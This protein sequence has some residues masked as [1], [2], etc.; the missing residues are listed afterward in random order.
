VVIITLTCYVLFSPLSVEASHKDGHDSNAG[1]GSSGGGS[2]KESG[3]DASA[4]GSAGGGGSTGGGGDTGSTGGSTGGTDTGGTDTGGSTGGSSGGDTGGSDGGGS[5]AGSGGSD[6]GGSDSGSSS[7]SSRGDGP[8]GS[9]GMYKDTTPPVAI[10]NGPYY[11]LEGEEIIFDAMASHDKGGILRY[12]WNFGNVSKAEGGSVRHVFPNQ[13]THTISLNVTDK[14]N[15]W[16]LQKTLA[17]IKNAPP[18]LDDVNSRVQDSC[19]TLAGSFSD[20]G[21]LDK[22]SAVIDWGDG[23]MKPADIVEEKGAGMIVGNHLYLKKGI[24]NIEIKIY[25]EDSYDSKTLPVGLMKQSDFSTFSIGLESKELVIERGNVGIVKIMS[26]ISSC[27]SEAIKLFASGLAPGTAAEFTTLRDYESF[28]SL[29]KV[30][31][32]P[33]AALGER[34]VTI[35]ANGGAVNKTQSLLLKIVDPRAKIQSNPSDLLKLPVLVTKN[36]HTLEDSLN[37]NF[38]AMVA[39]GVPPYAWVIDLGDGSKKTLKTD[40]VKAEISHDYTDGGEYD[41]H[42]EVSDSKGSIGRSEIMKVTVDR[43]LSYNDYSSFING[44]KI[45]TISTITEATFDSEKGSILLLA[46]GP[47]GSNGWTSLTISKKI[48]GPPFTVKVAGVNTE[49]DLAEEEHNH[50]LSFAYS[51]S[52]KSIMITGTTFL[53]IQGSTE[54]SAPNIDVAKTEETNDQPMLESTVIDYAD[55]EQDPVLSSDTATRRSGGAGP[56]EYALVASPPVPFNIPISSILMLIGTGAA[57]IGTAY[58]TKLTRRPASIV[59]EPASVVLEAGQRI[60]FIAKVYNNKGRLLSKSVNWSTTIRG[61]R[62]DDEGNFIAPGDAYTSD[63]GDTRLFGIRKG[64]VT[65]SYSDIIAST[66][67]EVH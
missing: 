17:T 34:P 6:T 9:G 14:A 66:K 11:A 61:A 65:A 21:I 23:T 16:V 25:D 46:S 55:S 28:T 63:T 53:P 47:D 51:H 26:K 67:V 27:Y 12:E 35:T 52:T 40:G 31:T 42:F 5:D 7:G 2:T 37:V 50:V 54:I 24:Y 48:L 45:L 18:L 33:W 38:Q 32:A 10:H 64:E 62:I 4:G 3:G 15:N 20:K 56:D 29:M 60:S 49:F 19:V 1:G 44:V 13:G 30:Y 57:G 8:S 36:E 39:G 58:Y 22:H 59:I 41:V 43:M